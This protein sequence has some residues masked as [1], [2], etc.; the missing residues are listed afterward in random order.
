MKFKIMISLLVSLF[1]MMS[2]IT[3]IS[4]PHAFYGYVKDSQGNF[5]S[6]GYVVTGEVNGVV[7][8]SAEINEGYYDL[9]V[10]DQ[11][12]DGGDVKFY[13]N[14][15]EAEE[16]AEFYTFDITQLNL[17]V[18]GVPS[19]FEG[20]GDGVCSAEEECSFCEVDCSY[21]ECGGNG[22][23]D[24]EVGEECVNAPEDCGVCDYCGDGICNTNESCSSCSVDCGVCDDDSD[25]GDSGSSNGGGGSSGG[26]VTRS[27]STSVPDMDDEGNK[28]SINEIKTLDELNQEEQERE[29]GFNSFL[30]GAVTGL[31]SAKGLVGIGLFLL[32]VLGAVLVVYNKKSVKVKG[33]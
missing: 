8:G 3:A 14:G 2:F 27:A 18:D 11:I 30:T 26:G 5:I 20:C 16:S 12:G 31:T 32:V 29:G 17:T 28:D 25:D 15:I 13:I 7:S 6:D 1:L 9:V 22:R 33:K 23:C 24:I 19:F 10:T 4:Y 21:Q